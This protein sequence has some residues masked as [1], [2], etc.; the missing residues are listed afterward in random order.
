MKQGGRS[1]LR[2]QRARTDGPKDEFINELQGHEVKINFVL[3]VN[4]SQAYIIRSILNAQLPTPLI[5]YI[6]THFSTPVR[7]P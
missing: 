5:K 7:A 4:N 1:F 2:S 3:P 6:K